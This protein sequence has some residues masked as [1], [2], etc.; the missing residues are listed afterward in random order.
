L[1]W[2]MDRWMQGINE[3]KTLQSQQH[4]NEAIQTYT[5]LRAAWPAEKRIKDL[6]EYIVHW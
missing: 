6:R 3:A 1:Q 2:C 4:F 5:A